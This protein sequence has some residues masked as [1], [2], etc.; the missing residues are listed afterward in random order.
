MNILFFKYESNLINIKQRLIAF[1]LTLVF[2]YESTLINI[3]LVIL[4]INSTLL[5][6]HLYIIIFSTSFCKYLPYN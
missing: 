5:F 2:T 6:L 3:K 1:L 4:I